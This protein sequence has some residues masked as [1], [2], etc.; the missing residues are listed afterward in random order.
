MRTCKQ[1]CSISRGGIEADPAV[2]SF[3]TLCRLRCWP[4]RVYLHVQFGCDVPS[5]VCTAVLKPDNMPN[6][7]LAGGP[8]DGMHS[9]M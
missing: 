5:A 9:D 7:Q 6:G 2:E 4:L 3:G 8:D 1:A